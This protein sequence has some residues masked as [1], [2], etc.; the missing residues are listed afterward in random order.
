MRTSFLLLSSALIVFS[1]PAIAKKCVGIEGAPKSMSRE[2][3]LNNDRKIDIMKDVRKGK[4][5][6]DQ[7]KYPLDKVK[8]VG[9]GSSDN[10]GRNLLMYACMSNNVQATKTLFN[11][12][13]DD[14]QYLSSSKAPLFLYDKE[15]NPDGKKDRRMTAKGAFINEVDRDDLLYAMTPLM[16]CAQY[17][18]V[19]VARLIINEK[20]PYIKNKEELYVNINKKDKNGRTALMYAA[21]FGSIEI[22]KMIIDKD[23]DAVNVKDEFGK[24]AIYYAVQNNDNNDDV[25]IFMPNSNSENLDEVCSC[26]T[27]KINKYF[28]CNRL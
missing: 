1:N 25:K 24:Q 23:K 27:R 5:I 20:K 13:A 10:I 17:N 9:L 12:L 3:N 14:E 21:Y 22:A 16:Y 28:N 11:Y 2:F 19:D 4:D 6:S 15:E 8:L 7:S 18:A 26:S